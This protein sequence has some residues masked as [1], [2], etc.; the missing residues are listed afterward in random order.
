MRWPARRAKQLQEPAPST[1]EPG[2]AGRGISAARDISGIASTG[3]HA[4]NVQYRAERMTVLP[5]EVFA[6]VAELEAPRGLVNLPSRP[7]LFVGRAVEL[8]RLDAVLAG[9]GGVVVQAVHGLG[10]IG[11]STLAAHWAAAHTA[12]H[13]LTWWI[14]ADSS[15]SINA[16]LARLGAAL[17]PALSDVLPAEALAERAVQWLAA[18]QGWLVILVNVPDPADVW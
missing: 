6:P 1:A 7:T 15:A 4:V 11:K 17:Q 18:H 12:D 3:D 14:T 13:S 10:G 5:A 9:P 2:P 16:G 8:G